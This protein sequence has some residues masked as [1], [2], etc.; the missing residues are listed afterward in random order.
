MA[1]L[2]DA[3]NLY[4]QLQADGLRVYGI[5]RKG[6][7]YFAPEEFLE[8]TACATVEEKVENRPMRNVVNWKFAKRDPVRMKILSALPRL[9]SAVWWPFTAR[10]EE[11]TTY[12]KGSVTFSVAAE[13]CNAVDNLKVAEIGR[14]LYGLSEDFGE[15][16]FDED[17]G[18]VVS[19]CEED[20]AD[21][22]KVDGAG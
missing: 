14:K 20:S 4:A 21:T 18:E 17:Q 12:P 8:Q 10:P 11:L 5:V 7:V 9:P 13:E 15:Q 3:E 19:G 22:D 6:N 2:E 16:A 1:R